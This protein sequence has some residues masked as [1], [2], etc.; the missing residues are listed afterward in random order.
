MLTFITTLRNPLNSANYDRVESL[1]QDTLAS[2]TQQTCDDYVVI[3]V[4]NRRPSFAL[5]ERVVFVEVDFP[6]PSGHKGPRTGPAAVIWDKGTKIAIGLIA[7]RAFAPE[8]VMAV[9]ADDFVHRELA[10]FVGARPGRP[11]WFVKRG[12]MYSSTRNAYRLH[13]R[14]YRAC[15]TSFIIPFDAYEVPLDLT[16]A[17]T[18]PEIAEAFGEKLEHVLEHGWAFDWWRD[19]G[20]VLEP[21]PFPGA[22][23]RLENG[24]N[25][26]GYEL[27]GPAWPYRSHLRR[28]FA[29]RSSR[30][31]ASTFWAALGP[32]ALKPNLKLPR[33]AFMQPKSYLKDFSPPTDPAIPS[34]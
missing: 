5:P 29:I 19:H 16:V 26:S 27:L 7:A 21:L 18:Q 2:L 1:L 15:G 3:I 9:D 14:F 12:W 33:P 34:R 10:A 24:E 22:V 13:R 30:T 23:Y 28:D 31:P 6:P 4:G 20:R 17:A 25:H 8:Y 11:G 32:A